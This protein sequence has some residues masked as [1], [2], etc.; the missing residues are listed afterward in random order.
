MKPAFSVIFFTVSSGAGLGL[1]A[2]LAFADL[3][4]WS[5]ALENKDVVIGGVLALL[6][7]TAGLL[8]STL[9]LA[10]PK[11]AWRSFSRFRTSWLSREGVFAVLFYP[12]AL[13]F[14]G[15]AY[16]DIAGPG[17]AIAAGGTLVLAWITLYCTGMIYASLKP[18]PQ[19]HTPLVPIG[20]LVLGHYSGALLLLAI[21]AYVGHAAP[22]YVHWVLTWLVLAAGV[23]AIYYAWISQ[24]D[25]EP[26]INMATGISR[27][28]VRLLDTGHSHGTFLTNEF[29]FILARQHAILVKG[30][31]FMLGFVAP[32][33]ILLHGDPGM[34]P[35]IIS[36]SAAVVGLVL[37][38]W[39]FFA[40]A[41]HVVRLYH[42]L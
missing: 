1:V 5:G 41:R 9:H 40:E 11:N 2:L 4:Q 23:K 22:S 37:E 25:M 27:A 29:G 16:F 13:A 14:I 8:S 10:N 24:R 39:L 34:G 18:I 38:R 12:F 6:L 36:I 33:L 35:V 21:L 26:T 28:R 31:V 42:G 32:L 20:Y 15:S 30:L 17:R 19:W 3:F 7:V